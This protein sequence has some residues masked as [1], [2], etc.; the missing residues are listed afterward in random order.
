MEALDVTRGSGILLAVSSLPSEYGIGTLGNAAYRFV[1][2]LV[3]LKQRYWQI[4]PIG[5]TSFG[6]SPYQ[7]MSAYA[8]NPY[9]IDLDLLVEDG[10][11]TNEEIRCYHWGTD[12]AMVDYSVLFENRYKVLRKAFERFDTEAVSFRDFLQVNKDWLDD[13]SLFMAIK[14]ANDNKSWLEWDEE[15]RK[16]QP[17]ALAN[18][19]KV[20][21]NDITFWGFCQYEFALQWQ[22][23]RDYAHLKGVQIIGDVPFFVATDS[24]DVWSHPELFQLDE[25]GNPTYVSAALPDKFSEDGQIWG[26]PLFDWKRMEKDGFQWWRRRMELS[27]GLYDIVRMDH[28]LGIIKNYSVP[29]G[30]TDTANGRWVKGPGRKLVNV[31]N[32]VLDGMAV[33]ADDYGGKALIPGAK[34]VLDKSG[35]MGTKVLMFAFDGNTANEHLPHNYLEYRTAVYVGT[36]DNETVVGYFRNKTEYELAYLYEYLNIRR[37]DDISDALIRAAYQSTAEITIVQMQD[38]LGLGNEARMN[39]PT[40]VGYNWRWRLGQEQLDEDRRAWIRNLAAVYRR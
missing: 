38:L 4:L 8:G 37:V 1:D 15:I 33:I 14:N 21:Y 39:A 30:A 6:D 10:L 40:T 7:P 26:T 13:Y 12:D 29:F 2:L 20:L 24:A 11:L 32:D 23:L 5:P 3:D 19:R 35:W 27:K 17:V 18:C 25:D 28:F 9:L 36:H 22:K 34:K 31:I 16:K